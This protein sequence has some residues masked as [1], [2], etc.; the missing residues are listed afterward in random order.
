MTAL[1]ASPAA[2]H[3]SARMPSVF[4]VDR[5][6]PCLDFWVDRLWIEPLVFRWARIPWSSL[7]L[8]DDRQFAYRTIDSLHE[9]TPGLIDHDQHQPWV[10]TRPRSRRF[11]PDPAPPRRAGG[12]RPA[13]RDDPRH[14][15]VLRP[16][17][18]RSAAS[19]ATSRIELG[20]RDIET[21]FRRRAGRRTR[22][23]RGLL[24][25]ARR[26]RSR[27]RQAPEGRRSGRRRPAGRA[28]FPA[29]RA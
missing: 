9:D 12:R 18:I 25:S 19:C 29:P 23:L 10:A 27:R 6:E 26:L 17:A 21:D 15:R 20:V 2:Y 16:R 3:L 1:D 4:L 14:P 24:R 5:I 11:R 28:P 13:P 8:G 22:P 7:T